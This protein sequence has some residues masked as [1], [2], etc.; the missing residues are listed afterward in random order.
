MHTRQLSL[1]IWI[2][3]LLLV[4]TARAEEIQGRVI[5]LANGD[6]LT[7]LV[8]ES[9]EV[10]VHLA[11]ID[12]PELSQPYGRQSLGVLATLVLDKSVKVKDQT[13]GRDGR[14]VAHV[15]V[16]GKDIN[17]VMVQQGAAWVDREFLKDKDLL[18][19]E[20]EARQNKE[21]LW[22]LPENKRVPPWEWRKKKQN[23]KNESDE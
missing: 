2:F 13:T 16:G 21:G 6:T 19:L 11:E 8:D 5:K 23:W 18:A 9:N 1:F 15:Y 3:S 10:K 20:Q 22:S 17:A 14:T 7:I 12:A 4:A